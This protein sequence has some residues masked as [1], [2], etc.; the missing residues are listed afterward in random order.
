VARGSTLANKQFSKALSAMAMR[1][2]TP[3]TALTG[4]MPTH[5]DAMRKI[6]M[7]TTNDMPVVRVDELGK[8]A[9][10]VVQVDC[11]HIIK[12]RPVMGDRNA[13]GLGAALKYSSKDVT[14]DMATLP[15]SAG[16]KMTQQRTPHD[17]R[18][19]ALAQLKAAIPRFRWQRALT[20][21][22]GARGAQDGNDWILPLATDPDFA[23]MMINTVKA[24]SYNRHFVV[25]GSALTQ[26]GLQ[27]AS[28][29]TTDKLKLAHIDE[30]AA[31]WDEMSVKMSALQIPGDP[32][33]GDDP[34]KGILYV[35]PLVWDG[36]VTETTS[37]YNI[38]TFEQNAVR[39]ASY[40]GLS[41][42]PLF[43]GTPLLWNG[44]LIRKM[45]Y[46]IRFNASDA[47]NYV[48]AANKLLAT[49]TAGTVAAGLSTTHQAARSI[50]LSAQALAMVSGGNKDTEESYSL[51]ETR[52][53]F[54]RNLELAGEVMG[55]EDKLR[56]ALPNAAGD[57]EMTDFGVLV[58]D[59]V[60]L[61]RNV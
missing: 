11:A 32:A 17:M 29:A 37:G 48:T 7:Q 21:L 5:D 23:D 49:E 4:S 50:F 12:L 28:I 14:L 2:P 42:H 20:L 25:N 41:K 26:G 24:P 33:S 60:V 56:W 3:L 31:L 36:L 39:R 18:K 52:T 46:A 38:R 15:V 58:I 55:A 10:D 44:V 30:L 51:L 13:E 45:Q 6:K 53:N 35:D 43:A 27:L 1:Q 57:L 54:G 9:G 61:K 59:S 8:G 16:G 40:D 22:A 34:I 47:Y 19:N